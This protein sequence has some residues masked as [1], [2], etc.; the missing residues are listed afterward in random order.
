MEEPKTRQIIIYTDDYKESCFWTWYRGGKPAMTT[1]AAMAE[2]TAEGERPSTISLNKWAKDGQWESRAQVMDL[3][4]RSQ[5]ERMAVREK[6]EMYQRQAEVGKDLI[7][8]AMAYME[9]EEWD[10]RTPANALAAIKYGSELER[11]TRGVSDAIAKLSELDSDKLDETIVS[12]LNA[13]RPEDLQELLI[14]LQ[15]PDVMEA[16]YTETQLLPEEP[17]EPAEAEGD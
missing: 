16:S 7:E 12:L 5:I 6:V 10:F 8:K 17:E 15:D 2:P 11:K 1:L 4:V 13:A 14:K 3:Q 9:D